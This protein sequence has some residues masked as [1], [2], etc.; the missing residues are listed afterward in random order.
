MIDDDLLSNWKRLLALREHV[1]RQLERLR[2]EKIIGTSLEATV[3]LR[4]DGVTMSLLESYKSFLP[5]LFIASNVVLVANESKELKS[6][7]K[8]DSVPTESSNIFVEQDDDGQYAG[9]ALIDVERT[10]GSKCDRCWRYV[11]SVSASEPNGLCSRCIKALTEA[12]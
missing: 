12:H 10:D 11:G 1:N 2:Q 3:L 6:V 7:T 9:S 4:S 5:T 8:Q